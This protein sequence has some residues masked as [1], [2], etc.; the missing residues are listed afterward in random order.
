MEKE[1]TEN[2]EKNIERKQAY[3]ILSEGTSFIST[4]DIHSC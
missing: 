1:R 3:L 2:G 4:Q